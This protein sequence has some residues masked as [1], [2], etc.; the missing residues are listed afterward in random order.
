MAPIWGGLPHD[1]L[2]FKVQDVSKT[3]RRKIG[4]SF[5]LLDY[6]FGTQCHRRNT[7]QQV[8]PSRMETRGRM[9][10]ATRVKVGTTKKS[11]KGQGLDHHQEEGSRQLPVL[12]SRSLPAARGRRA[13]APPCDGRKHHSPSDGLT[14]TYLASRARHLCSPLASGLPWYGPPTRGT[15][16]EQGG[17]LTAH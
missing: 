16:S 17:K 15:S 8:R 2:E 1:R 12:G 7:V 9:V 4:Q 14:S 6:E 10:E 11:P 5:V 3:A 13:L